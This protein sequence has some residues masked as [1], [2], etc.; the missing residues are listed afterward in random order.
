MEPAFLQKVYQITL[1]DSR[2]LETI[3]RVEPHVGGA[4]LPSQG[5]AGKPI[6]L[7][8]EGALKPLLP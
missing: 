4:R 6:D 1:A 8:M 3:G 2:S 7:G 5:K